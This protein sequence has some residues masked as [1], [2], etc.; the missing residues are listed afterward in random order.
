MIAKKKKK[1]KST[2]K[3]IPQLET[4]LWKV[5]SL[6]VRLKAVDKYNNCKCVTCNKNVPYLGGLCHA[7]HFRPRT[8]KFVKY[9][10]K[11]VHPQCATCNTFSDGEQYLHSVYIDKTYGRGTA[12]KLTI[13]ARKTFKEEG[14]DFRTYLEDKLQE[15]YLILSNFTHLEGWQTQLT[16]TELKLIYELQSK[17]K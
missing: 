17:P 9:D 3:T 12:S 13:D 11:N 16:K 8:Q 5:F 2:R 6:S 4:H 10:F 7:G 14:I 1:A 15:C